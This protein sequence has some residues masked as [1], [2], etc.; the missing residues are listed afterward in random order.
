MTTC[1][2]SAERHCTTLHVSRDGLHYEL[3]GI[4]LDH[5]NK[6]MILFEGK[7]DG[8]FMA[9]TRPLGEVYF[10]YPE[11]SPFAG[12]PSINL[13]QS[14]DALH[15]KPLDAP[16]IRARKGS[17]SSDEGRRRHP[18]DPDRARLAADLSRRRD[19]RD[20]RHL[21]QL[22]GAARSRR[23]V[24]HPAARGRSAA[25]R[26]Q[27]DAHLAD[28][29]T[30]C[31]CRRRSSSPPAS[32]TPATI[33]SSRPAKPI[34]PAASP[35]CPR[36]ASHERQLVAVGRHLSDLSAL[37]PGQRRRRRRRPARDRAAARL[38]RRA[39]RRRDLDLARSSP[40]RWRTSATT[41]PTI[42]T[43]IR[44]SGRSRISTR[45]SQRPC[46]G[47]QAAARFRPQSQLERAS[48]VRREPQRRATIRSAT[49]ISG[50]IPAPD[51]GPPNNWIS[52]FGGS[53]WEW[54]EATGQYYFHAFLKEQPDLNWRN[55][56][57][58]AA[59]IDVLR[60]W[61]DRGVDG[62]RID[63]L[64]HMIKAR[65]LSRQSAEP[66]LDPGDGR[67]A[68]GAAA[69]FDRPA[70]GARDRRRDACDRGSL[71]R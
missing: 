66:R 1:S 7:V 38:S 67:D 20:G 23:S 12:G 46:A 50:A 3:Q 32:P 70:R 13:A 69:P 68:P 60:F 36:R 59:M 22:L 17:T 4:V 31:T 24:A 64:W 41:W 15:W 42:A 2:V 48:L 52:D 33:T 10:A 45:C 51:G 53:A 9:L 43:S 14:P 49:G 37:V 19:A 44:A 63:V 47:P 8:R 6:D 65:R 28:R 58:R 71:A 27:P 56:D 57:L 61:F 26:G 25:A 39:R 18:A 21:S 55:P 40:R 30:R 29:A 16:G 54:D 34:S 11:D 35:S 62:F 5:Q